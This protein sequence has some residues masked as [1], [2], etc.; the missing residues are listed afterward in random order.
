[1]FEG[2][3][4]GLKSALSVLGRGGKLTEANIRDGLAQV[5]TLGDGH[6]IDLIA[7]E[8]VDETL[9]RDKRS[10]GLPRVELHDADRLRPQLVDRTASALNRT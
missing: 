2:I 8:R 10:A 5:H 6:P 1:M 7:A 9:V 3:A 4:N